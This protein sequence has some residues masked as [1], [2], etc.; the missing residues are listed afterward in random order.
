MSSSMPSAGAPARS[1]QLGC[2]F[3]RSFAPA[4]RI[5]DARVVL[6][7]SS[8]IAAVFSA[9]SRSLWLSMCSPTAA[10]ASRL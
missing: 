3:A 7:R 8:V 10:D 5:I 6:N 4:E 1:A 2:A 9:S